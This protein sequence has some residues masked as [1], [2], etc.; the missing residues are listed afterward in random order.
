[1]GEFNQQADPRVIGQRLTE[2][3]K[4]AGLTQ[5]DAADYLGLS[6]PTFIAI[7]KGVRE[8]KPEELIKLAKLYKRSV[9]EVVRPG[10][11]VVALE[12]HLRANLDAAERETAGLT[13]AIEELNDLATDYRELERLLNAEMKV[14]HPPEVSLPE[15]GDIQQFAESVAQ[16]ERARFRL[17]DGPIHDVRS[18]LEAHVGVRVFYGALPKGISGMYAYVPDLGYCVNINRLHPRTRRRASL[19]HEYGHFLCDRHKPG[20]DFVALSARK[21]RNELFCDAFS[22]AFLLPRT[23]VSQFFHDV[24]EA[25]GDFQVGDLVRLSDYYAASLEAVT[26]RLEA[27]GLV[28]RGTWDLLRS[29]SFSPRKARERMGIEEVAEEQ[30]ELLP[31]RYRQLAVRAFQQDLITEGQLAKFLRV[32][33]LRAR[34]IVDRESTRDI[35]ADDEPDEQHARLGFSLFSQH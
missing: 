23:G 4:A 21:P 31:E 15:R 20:I 22:M 25:T 19:T 13:Q 32:D 8:A 1:M 14:V 12:P 24:V 18:I 35:G 9:H 34:E 10:E 27:L 16:R 3:R 11:A 2:Y 30:P 5:A 6:R 26:R 29:Q 7:E 17:G 28:G 33:R